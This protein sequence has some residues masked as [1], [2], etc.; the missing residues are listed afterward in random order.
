MNTVKTIHYQTIQHLRFAL[1]LLAIAIAGLSC[2]TATEPTDLVVG[3]G[4]KATVLVKDQGGNPINGARVQWALVQQGASQQDIDAAFSSAATSGRES[5]TG[6]GTGSGLVQF[7][8][9]VP[10]ADKASLVVFKT[11]PPADFEFVGN[12]KNGNYRIDTT[13]VCGQTFAEFVLDRKQNTTCTAATSCKDVE[14]TIEPRILA[15]KSVSEGDFVQTDGPVTISAVTGVPNNIGNISSNVNIVVPGS[16][17]QSIPATMNQNQRFRV[18]FNFDATNQ[19]R[20]IDTTFPVTITA[21]QNGQPCWTCTFNLH[22]IV[23]IDLQCDCPAQGKTLVI[24]AVGQHVVCVGDKAK[25]TT[26][27]VNMRN[28]NKDCGL[29]FELNHSALTESLNDVA[30]AAMNDTPTERY[31]VSPGAVLNTITIRFQP[32]T[33]KQFR[34]TFRFNIFRQTTSGLVKCDSL[35]TIFYNGEG[36][37]PAF[38]IDTANSTIFMRSGPGY[39]SDTLRQ[40]TARKD[41][42]RGTRRICI[43]NPGSCELNVDLSLVGGDNSLFSM[44]SQYVKIPAGKS[45]CMDIHFNPKTS[46]VYPNGRCTP[47]RL[48]FATTIR[49]QSNVGTKTAPVIGKA[50]PDV[51]C[52]GKATMTA[53]QFGAVD[54]AGTTYYIVLDIQQDNTIVN[55]EQQDGNTDSVKIYV[56]TINTTGPPP[57]D[58]NI[59]SAILATGTGIPVEYNIVDNKLVLNKDICQLFNDYGC[60]FNNASWTTQPT[61]REGDILLFRYKGSYGIMWIKKLSWS[62]RGPQAIPQVEGLVCYPFN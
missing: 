10:V 37:L 2:Q 7:V 32:Q 61:V 62:N 36:G 51:Q 12:Q 5:M 16:N 55:G 49:M 23:K 4:F 42:Q 57:N 30:I 13:A 20:S 14:I 24:P 59:T 18:Q 25:D 45:A 21:L 52:A 50:E 15:K 6:N 26:F 44:D 33:A 40:C 3:N 28:D 19:T 9:P 46:D 22:L 60:N 35:L 47:P 29:L 1:L 38:V 8:I 41:P 17:N 43:S 11:I 48:N 39:I 56:R 34:Q 27:A 31:L 58:A 53:F 54:A